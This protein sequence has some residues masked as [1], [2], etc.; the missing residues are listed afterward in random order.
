MAWVET[1]NSLSMEDKL[2]AGSFWWAG[3]YWWDSPFKV[4]IKKVCLNTWQ[5]SSKC[6][7][8]CFIVVKV[9]YKSGPT[10]LFFYCYSNY[11]LHFMPMPLHDAAQSLKPQT[12]HNLQEVCYIVDHNTLWKLVFFLE[13]LM[14]LSYVNPGQCFTNRSFSCD[15]IAAM[16]EDDNKRFLISFYC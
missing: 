9:V 12:E 16:L 15:V 1:N 10:L 3:N 2:V 13:V 8:T 6:I 4:L 5:H 11:T 7:Q 14:K